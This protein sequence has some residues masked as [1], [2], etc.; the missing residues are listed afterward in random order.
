MF[1]TTLADLEGTHL[2]NAARTIRAFITWRTTGVTWN[3]FQT[4]RIRTTG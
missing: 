1:M 3:T 2:G 4:F